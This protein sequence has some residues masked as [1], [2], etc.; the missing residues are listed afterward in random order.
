MVRSVAQRRV[1]NHEARTLRQ[2]TCTGACVLPDALLPSASD[3]EP[4]EEWRRFA[5]LWL[6]RTRDCGRRHAA[7]FFVDPL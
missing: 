6:F 7:Q 1:S 2:L 3:A 4:F 5:R